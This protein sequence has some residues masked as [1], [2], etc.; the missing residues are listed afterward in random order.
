MRN[1]QL[2]NGVIL[3]ALLV[4]LSVSIATETA[5]ATPS[6]AVSK[7]KKP[8]DQRTEVNV[9]LLAGGTDIGPVRRST[10]GI[11]VEAGRRFGDLVLLGEYNYLSLGNGDAQVRGTMSRLGVTARY[12]LLRTRSLPKRGKRRGPVSGDYWLELGAG[13]QRIAWDDGGVVHRPD[14]VGGFGWQFNVVIDRKSRKPKYYGPFV[15]FRVSAARAPESSVE[16]PEVCTGPC[17]MATAPPRNDV[18]VFFHTGI[19]WGR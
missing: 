9:G 5:Y 14:I 3:S 17:D 18:S 12:S 19:N 8:K 15:A 1:K 2:K 6:I 10:V 4:A 7:A 16:L 11:T 13:M